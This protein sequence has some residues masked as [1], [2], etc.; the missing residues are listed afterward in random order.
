MD[1]VS[2]EQDSRERTE[3]PQ[4]RRSGWWRRRSVGIG[5]AALVVVVAAGVSTYC[6]TRRPV[7]TGPV[8]HVIVISLDTTRRDHFGCYGNTWIRTPNVDALAAES[9]VFTDYITVATTTLAS[10]TSLFTGKYPHTHGVPRN[11][12]MVNR[13]NVMLA[14]LLGDAG[15]TSAGFVGAFSLDSLFDFAQGFDYY[16]QD[17]DI[18]VGRRGINQNQRTAAAV[19]DTVIEYLQRGDVP[20][21][22]FLFVHYFD[23]HLPYSP[24]APYKSMYGER[25]GRHEVY[26]SDHPESRFDE[27]LEA[28]KREAFLYAGEVSYLDAQ[29]GRLIDY[30]R[31]RGILD[32]AIVVLTSDHGENLL[33]PRT[34]VFDHGGSVYPAEVNAVCM[35]RLPGALQG[36][37]RYRSLTASIDVLPTLASYLGLPIPAGVEGRALDLLNLTPPATEPTRFAEATKPASDELEDD[38]LWFNTRKAQCARRGRF[39]YIR[40]EHRGT[41]GLYDLSVDPYGR[42]NL[43]KDP[44]WQDAVILKK[45]RA[46]LAE[47]SAEAAPLPTRFEPSQRSETSRRLRSLGYLGGGD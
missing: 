31:K 33:D 35:V 22:L 40:T 8:R 5:M 13:D 26:V 46:A 21:N 34:R 1:S 7:Y 6:L 15:F 30:L 38:Q 2:N 20:R 41:E 42:R 18:L 19:T 39:E 43:L 29:L 44:G 32:E 10:H 4:P 11:G 28:D 45:L 9:I 36:G 3:Q 23:P 12:F 17:F 14:E 24:P 27:A 25:S 47:W 37:K 16:D